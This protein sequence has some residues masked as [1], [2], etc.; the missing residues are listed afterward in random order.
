MTILINRL[1]IIKIQ[2][3]FMYRYFSNLISSFSNNFSSI[4]FIKIYCI[5]SLQ[6]VYYHVFVS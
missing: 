3:I 4:F 1:Y 2:N 5:I 6:Y